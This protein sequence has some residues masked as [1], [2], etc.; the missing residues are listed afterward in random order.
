MKKFHV[1]YDALSEPYRELVLLAIIGLGIGCVSFG[2][3]SL[4]AAGI[5]Y[6][7]IVVWSRS[8]HL[9]RSNGN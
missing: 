3:L 1:W 5:V 4:K 7:L 2:T 6:F 8:R 9:S